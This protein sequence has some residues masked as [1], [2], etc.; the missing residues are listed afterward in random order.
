MSDEESLKNSMPKPVTMTCKKP[1]YWDV[2]LHQFRNAGDPGIIPPYQAT[3]RRR[4]RIH[5][6]DAPAVRFIE[7]T[8]DVDA[9]IAATLEKKQ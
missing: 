1:T 5:P 2:L 3:Y 9:M 8:E 7:S 4:V 6:D